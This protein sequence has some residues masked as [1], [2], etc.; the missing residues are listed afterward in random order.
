MYVAITSSV[1]VLASKETS[2]VVKGRG[3]G[4][5][6]RPGSE[7]EGRKEGE[8]IISLAFNYNTNL[9]Q[10]PVASKESTR[11]PTSLQRYAKSVLKT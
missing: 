10:C 6:R 11:W 7:S 3:R 1:V 5:I 4:D 2:K 8:S 9:A